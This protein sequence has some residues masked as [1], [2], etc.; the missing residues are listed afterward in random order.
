[1]VLLD[2]WRLDRL[3][4]IGQR[5]CSSGAVYVENWMKW[6]L[7][8][9]NLDFSMLFIWNFILGKRYSASNIL[10][11][12][13]EVWQSSCICHYLGSK[14]EVM[15]HSKWALIDINCIEYI[16]VDLSPGR[17]RDLLYKVD[18]RSGS[19]DHKFWFQS[20]TSRHPN[21]STSQAMSVTLKPIERTEWWSTCLRRPISFPHQALIVMEFSGN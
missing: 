20:R 5:V 6:M 15:L 10:D 14:L 11:N 1:M 17:T 19:D 21:S 9:K 12:L 13:T 4:R 8:R 7:I 3:W 18:S 16:F 2:L